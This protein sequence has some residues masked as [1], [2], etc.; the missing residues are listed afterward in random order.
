MK[1]YAKL[2]LP[3]LLTILL[4]S[5]C[6][7]VS[8]AEYDKVVAERDALQALIDA[9]ENLVDAQEN[10]SAILNNTGTE[11]ILPESTPVSDMEKPTTPGLQRVGLNETVAS[12]KLNITL[13]AC[14]SMSQVYDSRASDLYYSAD[15]GMKFAIMF[16][17][18]EN[19]SQESIIV[20]GSNLFYYADNVLC[21]GASFSWSKINGYNE[22]DYETLNPGRVVEGYVAYTIPA[23]AK[24]LEIEYEGFIFEY[25]LSANS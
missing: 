9:K 25:D 20:P 18:L 23:D 3:M 4:L 5:A 17:R 21:T 12:D 24:L 7:G 8:Q 15:A 19:I 14:S 13:L 11:T 6:G 2:C 22:I 10:L 1:K 16:F